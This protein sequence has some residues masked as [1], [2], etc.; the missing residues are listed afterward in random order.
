[1][2]YGLGLRVQGT[3]GFTKQ[4]TLPCSQGKGVLMCVTSYNTS[5]RV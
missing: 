1:M 3:Q 2:V 5:F 4:I